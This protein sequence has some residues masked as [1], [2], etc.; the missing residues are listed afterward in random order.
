MSTKLS[1]VAALPPLHIIAMSHPS[2]ATARVAVAG[3][4]DLATASVLRETLLGVLHTQRHAVLDL[5]LADVTFLDCAGIGALVAVRNAAVDAGCRVRV[6]HPEP[7]VRR[8]LEVTGLLDVFAATAEP[9]PHPT[10]Q[11]HPPEPGPIPSQD[12]SRR[13]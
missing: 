5:D 2:P 7:I 12:P 8:V 4:V 1:P 6:C 13:Q 9:E 3:E 10:G 11:E